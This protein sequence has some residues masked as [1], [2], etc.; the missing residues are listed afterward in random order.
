MSLQI[1]LHREVLLVPALPWFCEAV[2]ME[3]VQREGLLLVPLD[4]AGSASSKVCV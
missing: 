3:G 4:L 1:R 2:N